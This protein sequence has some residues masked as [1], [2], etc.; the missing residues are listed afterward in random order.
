MSNFH[1]EATEDDLRTFFSNYG[2]VVGHI[3]IFYPGNPKQ[4]ARIILN[5]LP[6]VHDRISG[7]DFEVQNCNVRKIRVEIARK[8]KDKNAN[9]EIK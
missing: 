6:N 9:N 1:Y 4:N 7:Q 2:T 8:K 3:K 5:A